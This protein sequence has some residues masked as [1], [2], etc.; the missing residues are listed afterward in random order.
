MKLP[1]IDS[2]EIEVFEERKGGLK[3]LATPPNTGDIDEGEV[4][5]LAGDKENNDDL[6]DSIQN[7]SIDEL[8]SSEENASK[9][10]SDTV[11]KAKEKVIESEGK[12]AK[13]NFAVNELVT[14]LNDL[15]KLNSDAN[16]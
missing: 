1:R 9:V 11:I 14:Y 5:C 12:L 6:C 13:M 7:I 10:E 8:Q 2:G 16:T 4:V 3:P 15:A